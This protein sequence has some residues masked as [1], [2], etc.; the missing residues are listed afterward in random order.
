[1]QPSSSQ[2]TQIPTPRSACKAPGRVAAH[3]ATHNQTRLLAPLRLSPLQGHGLLC[4]AVRCAACLCA[5]Q[6]WGSV[7]GAWVTTNHNW[8]MCRGRRGVRRGARKAAAPC[9][10]DHRMHCHVSSQQPHVRPQD[11]DTE[12]FRP[13]GQ[14]LEGVLA[15]IPP[16]PRLI[17]PFASCPCVHNL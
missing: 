6:V 7:P 13:V 1:M 3:V 14:S 2:L 5:A 16:C 17:C 15:G 12:C 8:V 11:L 4:A 9:M 10:P